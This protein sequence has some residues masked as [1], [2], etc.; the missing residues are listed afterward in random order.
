MELSS[1][2]FKI[3]SMKNLKK[4]GVTDNVNSDSER[5]MQKIEWNLFDK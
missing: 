4:K 5:V 2:M 3:N 1:K